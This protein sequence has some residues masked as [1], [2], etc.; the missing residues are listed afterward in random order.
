MKANGQQLGRVLSVL[1]SIAVF[2]L[3]IDRIGLVPAMTAQILIAAFAYRGRSWLEALL[4]VIF[5]QTGLIAV[6]VLLIG[7]R[8]DLFRWPF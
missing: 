2:G 6:F 1:V 7:I 8:I 4:L 5:V 3:L